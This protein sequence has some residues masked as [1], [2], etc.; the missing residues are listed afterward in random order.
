M[1]RTRSD[2]H[3]QDKI[4]SLK[5]RSECLY[6]VKVSSFL[7]HGQNVFLRT[8]SAL[9]EDKVRVRTRSEGHVENMVKRSC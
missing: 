8:Q 9:F 7:G 4:R 3:V 6:E 1:F 2:G 5:T